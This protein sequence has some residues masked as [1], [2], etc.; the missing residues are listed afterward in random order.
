MA[1]SSLYDFFFFVCVCYLKK[2]QNKT[3]KD[4]WKGAVCF[5]LTSTGLKTIQ[6]LSKESTP[7]VCMYSLSVSAYYWSTYN[8]INFVTWFSLAH[9]HSILNGLM[10]NVVPTSLPSALLQLRKILHFLPRRPV[11]WN[12][13]GIS[14]L[15]ALWRSEIDDTLTFLF[16]CN[17]NVSTHNLWEVLCISFLLCFNCTLC[18]F[19]PRRTSRC[20]MYV[21]L[22]PVWIPVLPAMKT[23]KMSWS[24]QEG[25]AVLAEYICCPAPPGNWSEKSNCIV[26]NFSP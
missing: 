21:L 12:H 24:L 14:T 13:N 22:L 20:R 5:Y 19:F 23:Q 9:V 3:N 6:Y 18:T 10:V 7:G 26:N 1:K 17:D 2:K 4:L 25:I 8:F 15:L 11:V 16:Y